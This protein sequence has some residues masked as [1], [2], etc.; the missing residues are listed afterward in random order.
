MR[1][2]IVQNSIS[3]KIDNM[4]ILLGRIKTTELF[5]TTI[6]SSSSQLSEKEKSKGK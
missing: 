3:K 2:K 4:V 1:E 5:T 6:S